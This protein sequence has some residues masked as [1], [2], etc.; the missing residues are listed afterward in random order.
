MVTPFYVNFGQ[1]ALENEM[2]SISIISDR[3]HVNPQ[4][5]HY[6]SPI[7]YGAGEVCGRNAFLVFAALM[8]N[9]NI[10]GTL[11]MGLHSGTSYYDC[12]EQFTHDIQRLLDGYSSGQIL[13][14]APF[15]EWDKRMVFQYSLDN[16]VPIDMTYSCERGGDEPCGVCSS[17]LDRRALQC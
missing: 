7:T 6:S 12:S 15:L 3:Y 9:P 17:C 10:S 2:R 5:V 8:A 14:E 11:A 13:F 16:G 4:I 1:K